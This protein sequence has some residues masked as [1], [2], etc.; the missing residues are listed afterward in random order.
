MSA[1]SAVKI[2]VLEQGLAADRMEAAVQEQLL[3]ELELLLPD[4][5]FRWTRFDLPG[6]RHD[7]VIP[8]GAGA[9]IK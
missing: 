9:E 7:D 8:I 3:A 5:G 4:D 6:P 1:I 2:T